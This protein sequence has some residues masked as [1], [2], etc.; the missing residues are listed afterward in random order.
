MTNVMVMVSSKLGI[1]I[2]IQRV[3]YKGVASG[4]GVLYLIFLYMCLSCCRLCT[5]AAMSSLYLYFFSW[6]L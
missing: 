4:T 5:R 6:I 3:Q 2:N 1:E